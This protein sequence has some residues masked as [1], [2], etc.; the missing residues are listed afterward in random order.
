M[1][2]VPMKIGSSTSIPVAMIFK[3]YYCHKCGKRL[4]HQKVTQV[5]N[6]GDPGYEAA[7][8]QVMDDFMIGKSSSVSVSHYVFACPACQ[9]V[10]TFDEQT[11]IAVK[12]KY[13]KSHVL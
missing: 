12:Q 6:P 10:I 7:R 2:G 9:T 8:H 1:K 13:A 3:K 11:D 4:K 5:F